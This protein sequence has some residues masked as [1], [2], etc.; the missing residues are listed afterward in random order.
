MKV[1]IWNYLHLLVTWLCSSAATKEVSSV[2]HMV[3]WNENHLVDFPTNWYKKRYAYVSL[4]LSLCKLIEISYY[5]MHVL[6]IMNGNLSVSD[7]Q[8]TCLAVC[9]KVNA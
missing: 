8:F 1:R 7:S 9:K 3:G 5:C 4:L 2:E 6:F